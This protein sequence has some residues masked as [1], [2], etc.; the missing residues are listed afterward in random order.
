MAHKIFQ[1]SAIFQIV[2]FGMFLFIRSGSFN[3]I[4]KIIKLN[5]CEGT[6]F[7]V[8]LCGLEICLYMTVIAMTL[9][10]FFSVKKLFGTEPREKPFTEL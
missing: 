1:G 5:T 6:K 7:V 8:W 10:A 2:F 3:G 4:G 9:Y